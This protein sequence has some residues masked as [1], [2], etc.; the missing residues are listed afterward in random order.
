MVWFH[1]YK[2]SSREVAVSMVLAAGLVLA[3]GTLVA[4]AGCGGETPV[5]S[6]GG[7]TPPPG[8]GVN[9]RIVSWDDQL[10]SGPILV[11]PATVDEVTI[12]VSGVGLSDHTRTVTNP[13]SLIEE[14]LDVALGPTRRFEITARDGG[15]QT[16]YRGVRYASLD[17]LDQTVELSM[18]TTTDTQAPDFSGVSS[19]E[20][21]AD[22][23][24]SLSW[25]AASENGAPA[26]DTTYLIYLATTSGGQNYTAPA[27]ATSPG[28]LSAVLTG[29][30]PSTTY[31]TVARAMDAAGNVEAN[32]TELSAITFSSGEGIY[33]DVN[34]GTDSPTCGTPG[35]PCKTITTA[36]DHTS[37]DE[38]IFMAKGSYSESSGETFPLQL[39]PGTHL[40]GTGNLLS[41]GIQL[42]ETIIRSTTIPMILGAADAVVH[43]CVVRPNT[44]SGDLTIDSNGYAMEISFCLIDGSQSPNAEGVSLADSGR[45]HSSA[46]QG[47]LTAVSLYGDGA[48]VTTSHFTDAMRAIDMFGAH[49]RVAH[50][51]ITDCRSG[52]LAGGIPGAVD[53][54]IYHNTIRDNTGD[55]IILAQATGFLVEANTILLNGQT[56]IVAT[57]RTDGDT[58][59]CKLN[60]IADNGYCGIQVGVDIS[61]GIEYTL[62]AYGNVIACNDA[63]NL[64]ALPLVN[65]DVRYNHWD[66]DPPTVG[67]DPSL[68]PDCGGGVDICYFGQPPT[69]LY[70]PANQVAGC[71][72]GALLVAAPEPPGQRLVVAD[73]FQ[74]HSCTAAPFDP[75]RR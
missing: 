15:G 28:E 69:P 21:L 47:F 19:M 52:I 39:K 9:V 33:V 71:G 3:A 62:H 72:I 38:P 8:G 10:A 17:S 11:T 30:D 44:S 18:V 60:T 63:A 22:T 53:G 36:L 64:E 54:V 20:P 1:A 40:V 35:N 73:V 58:L 37:G 67:T 45:V 57:G 25:Q 50:D 2:R 5:S 61:A 49:Q 42:L 51:V 66:H 16:I 31:Y 59:V 75:Q 68:V 46:F 7:G 27:A 14:S 34:T 29:L 43:A 24:L 4:F 70:Q 74:S 32:Q 6:D 56:G 65:A 41:N 12:T 55:G 48:S 23:A 26:E 13:D